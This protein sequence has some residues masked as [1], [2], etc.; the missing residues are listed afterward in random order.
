MKLKFLRDEDG[1][2]WLNKVSNIWSRKVAIK[3]EEKPSFA[4]EEDLEEI[5]YSKIQRQEKR[6]TTVMNPFDF[7]N[8][9]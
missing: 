3:E 5:D 1:L 4:P 7:G 2:I 6:K 9:A 8:D